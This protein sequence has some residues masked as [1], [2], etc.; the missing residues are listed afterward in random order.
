MLFA[1]IGGGIIGL[2]VSI[3]YIFNGRVTGISGIVSGIL[4]LQKTDLN[5]RMLFTLGLIAGG[6]LLALF[7]PESFDS[8]SKDMSLYD[9]VLAGLLVGFGTSLG[10][11][12]TSGHGVCG[13]SR[14]SIRSIVATLV[15]I[16]SGVF[17]VLVF[18]LLKGEL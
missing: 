2:A 1:I 17:S 9:Y 5:W 15:F 18:K 8:P 13:I 3:M 11:G 16:S 6:V 12:C 10:S 4:S 14:L 7:H